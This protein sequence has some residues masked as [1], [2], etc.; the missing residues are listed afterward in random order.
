M[1]NAKP[2]KLRMNGGCRGNSIF[3]LACYLLCAAYCCAYHALTTQHLA[4]QRGRV[5][6]TKAR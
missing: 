3:D 4:A 5:L 6:N 2:A 1:F